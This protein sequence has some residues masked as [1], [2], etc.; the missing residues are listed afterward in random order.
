V[1]AEL[2]CAAAE[3]S[4]AATTASPERRLGVARSCHYALAHLITDLKTALLSLQPRLSRHVTSVLT[5]TVRAIP[6]LSTCFP[7]N[8]DHSTPIARAVVVAT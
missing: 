2:L 4:T 8:V 3:F 6:E 1:R 7:S 5:N